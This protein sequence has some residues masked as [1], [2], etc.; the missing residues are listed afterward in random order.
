MELGKLMCALVR[1]LLRFKC[2][3]ESQSPKSQKWMSSLGS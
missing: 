3:N 2:E 1:G